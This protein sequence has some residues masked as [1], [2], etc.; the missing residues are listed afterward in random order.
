ME[1]KNRLAD[2]RTGIEKAAQR[3]G[4]DPATIDIVVAG[5]YVDVPTLAVV[6]AAGVTVVGENQVQSAERKIPQLR[7]EFPRVSW[8]LI[9]HL[10]SNK[11]R[12]AVALFDAIHSLDSVALAAKISTYS[13]EAGKVMSVLIQVNLADESAKS[14]VTGEET[15]ALAK[16][17]LGLPG[18]ELR[19]LMT[20]PPAVE[21]AEDNR[22]HFRQLATLRSELEQTLGVRFATLSM[23]TSQDYLVAVEEGSTM[24]RLGSALFAL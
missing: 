14:G 8:Q 4:R 5:K 19:G 6:L 2:I 20:M 10:Q 18:L 9:G 12:R 23:G 13:L 24:V 17:V 7:S 15:M 21:S 16:A 1:I 22:A 11:T 3:V